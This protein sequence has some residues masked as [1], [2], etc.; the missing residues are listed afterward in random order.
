MG[1]LEEEEEEEAG[2]GGMMS[3]S[4]TGMPISRGASEK[5]EKS[6]AGPRGTQLGGQYPGCK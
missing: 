3:A 6:E 2:E 4:G 5:K 1:E